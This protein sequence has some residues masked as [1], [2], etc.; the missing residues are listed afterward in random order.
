MTAAAE[1][2]RVPS[3]RRTSYP[4]A[5]LRIL[6]D[7]DVDDYV[8]AR[9]LVLFG[10]NSLGCAKIAECVALVTSAIENERK[11]YRR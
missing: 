6:Y 5:G 3:T 10:A 1:G 2:K 11:I 4:G 9:V 7:D 8:Y